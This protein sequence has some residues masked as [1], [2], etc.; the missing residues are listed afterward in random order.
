MY[1]LSQLFGFMDMMLAYQCQFLCLLSQLFHNLAMAAFDFH[2]L[3][4]HM[5]QMSAFKLRDA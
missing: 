2:V 1:H 4:G 3:Y 5:A